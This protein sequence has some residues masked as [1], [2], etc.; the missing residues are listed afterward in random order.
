MPKNV[1]P[2]AAPPE[3]SEIWKGVG[4]IV[5]SGHLARGALPALSE[6]EFGMIMLHN[7]FSRWMVRCMAA[8]GVPDLSAVDVLVLHNINHRDKAKTMADISLM[9]NIEDTHIVAYALKKLQRLGLIQ[10]GRRGKE[11]LVSITPTGRN[12]CERYAAI[13]EEL[14]VK[15]VLSAQV[16]AE[17]LSAIAAHMRTLSGQYDQGTRSAASL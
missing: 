15:S 12:V 14:L 1:E 10:S 4:P 2:S 11:K 8:A 6:L 13:R 17:T 5:S 9:L 7:A 16:P 3:L